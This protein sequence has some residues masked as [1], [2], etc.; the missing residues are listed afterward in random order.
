MIA[1][2]GVAGAHVQFQANKPSIEASLE[3]ALEGHEQ[4]RAADEPLSKADSGAFNA[5]Q[6]HR[7]AASV[8]LLK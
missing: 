7:M 5:A 3:M 1:G 4:G 2:K 8:V 6:M